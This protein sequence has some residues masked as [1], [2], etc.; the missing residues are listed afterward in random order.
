MSARLHPA[1]ADLAIAQPRSDALALGTILG[2]VVLVAAALLGAI[3]W[4]NGG[5]FAYTLDAPYTHLALAEQIRGGT[6]G[7]NAGEPASP[8]STILFP[9]LLALLPFGQFSA[10]A[11]N[12]LSTLLSAAL[13]YALAKERGVR[14]DLVPLPYLAAL[15]VAF[16]LAFN[17][18]GL[19]FAGLE[20]SL[21]VTLTV[22]SL[23][24]LVRFI[25]RREVDRWWL[26]S[27]ILLPL[28]RFEAAAALLADVAV[29][30]AF[31]KLRHAVGV[32]VVGGAGVL[33][34]CLYLHSLGLPFLPSSILSR[35][36][37]AST[38]L[39]LGDSG[40]VALV[41]AVYST[42]KLNLM[43]Y[44]GTHIAA[45]LVV[46]A[47][48]LRQ[49]AQP[50]AVVSA[51]RVG[52]T[53]M[54]AVAFFALIA[55][56]QLAGG[57]L[58]SFSRYEI[59]VLVLG[60]GAFLVVYPETVRSFLKRM[61]L[62]G[63]AALC[64]AVLF[65]FSGYV[66]RTIDAVSASGNVHDQQYQMH[67][68]V[69]DYYRLPVA[70]NHPGWIDYD[71]PVYVLDLSGLGSEAARQA[72]HAR[73]PVRWMDE[74]AR[75]K[76][77]GLALMYDNAQPAPPEAWRPV[78]RLKLVQRA[79]TA[80]GTSVTLYA[81]RPEDAPAI[82]DAARRFAPTLPRGAALEFVAGAAPQ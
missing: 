65:V 33:A 25:R 37:V 69:A 8:S 30:L 41:R 49:P 45:M 57:S 59:Y 62:G 71:S 17:L 56:A 1:T 2:S 51:P 20:H 26:V 36:A 16:T 60:L 70:A 42:L 44:G 82:L 11:V 53:R 18:V 24:G 63:C 31:G 50:V 46:L 47:W 9:F 22:A 78:A 76:G 73:L 10:L 32:A 28:V 4:R 19:A 40:L 6:Y 64:A 61:R 12:M 66:F 7:L 58:S 14:L 52:W 27:I 75:A 79:V 34:F 77:V 43:A 29:L 48:G 74:M 15:T 13:I 38:G 54:A 68:F 80:Y 67:R 23:L 3:L 5:H 35:S 55:L 81:V 39:D 21:H 72:L